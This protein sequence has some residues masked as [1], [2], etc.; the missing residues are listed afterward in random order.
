M[1][2]GGSSVQNVQNGLSGL[3][4]GAKNNT[5]WSDQMSSNSSTNGSSSYNGGDNNVSSVKLVDG[6]KST[7]HEYNVYYEKE[8]IRTTVTHTA[9]VVD[10]WIAGVYNDF[11]SKLNNL[12]VGLD[13]E[14]RRLRENST[15]NPV[16]VLQL[17]LLKRC[18]IFQ[19]SCCDY[20]PNS[21]AD[22]LSNEKFTF[23]GVGIDSDAHKLWVD[24]GLNVART[25][26]LGSLAAYKLTKT[27]REYRE[28]RLYKAG[29]RDL[30]RDVL[31]Q[32]LPKKRGIQ[33]SHW[34]ND[35]LTDYQIEYACLDAFVSFKL[36]INLMARVNPVHT[37]ERRGQKKPFYK[38]FSQP[39]Q[40]VEEET[41][42]VS[43]K[44][45]ANGSSKT[46]GTKSNK[47]V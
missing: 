25:Q 7:H 3:S 4:L 43:E 13:I 1:A 20:I 46:N 11:P 33:L 47:R 27:V 10:Q 38:D 21:L 41:K 44:R 30:A 40:V 29:L 9:S 19:I 42:Q 8:K 2:G 28:S 5:S 39:K 6:S 14:W 12:V 45:A 24:H 35:F 15:R 32:K 31:G 18:L 23:V 36:A 17:C 16:A 22:F 26:E 34:D 37:D